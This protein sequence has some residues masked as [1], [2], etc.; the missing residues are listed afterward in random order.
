MQRNLPLE[1]IDMR[2]CSGCGVLFDMREIDG[3]RAWLSHRCR[4]TAS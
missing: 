1:A 3:V 4:F 2:I